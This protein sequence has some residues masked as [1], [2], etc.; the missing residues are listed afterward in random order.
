MSDNPGVLIVGNFLS[1]HLGT[2]SYCEDLAMRLGQANWRPITAS[3]KVSKP[4]R[5][6][7]MLYTAWRHR[8]HYQ[9]AQVDVFNDRAFIWA[10][11]TCLALRH[12]RKPYVLTIHAGNM[13]H[14]A[15]RYPKRV[16]KLLKSAQRVTT[17]SR[18]LARE[19]SFLHADI[20]VIP[21]AVDLN[22]Y[23]FQERLIARPRLIWLR[24]FHEVYNPL[25]AVETVRLLK[26]DFHDIQLLMIGPDK[27]D[28]TLDAIRK[29]IE[30]YALQKNVALHKAIPKSQVP[31]YLA[32]YDVF[33]NTTTTESF[34][35]SVLE[36]AATGLCIVTTAVGELPL[37]WT[38]EYDALLTLSNDPNAMAYAVRRV[39]TQP[40]LASRL[41]RN[42]RA[43]AEQYDWSAILPQWQ[44]LLASVLQ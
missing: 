30:R 20:M 27:H 38:N 8:H 4:F 12:F 44:S 18:Y 43:T 15:R 11:I 5:L 6:W 10:E 29:A 36:A 13:P 7:D 35:V 1:A 16:G 23:S 28:G 40:D 39:L 34:G 32:A 21:N 14:F 31:S 33:L 19:L 9:I 24:A 41:S 3:D 42:A 17:P 22:A 26:D 25:L 2:R 37:L